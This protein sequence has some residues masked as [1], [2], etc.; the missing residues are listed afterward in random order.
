MNPPPVAGRL[1]PIDRALW[2]QIR[3]EQLRMLLGQASA[4]TLLATGFAFLLAHYAAGHVEARQVQCWLALKV[5]VT[6]PRIAQALS[7]IHI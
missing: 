2:Q 5:L 4:V 3:A 7:L 1:P 6:L